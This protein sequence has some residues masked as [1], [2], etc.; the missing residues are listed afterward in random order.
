MARAKREGDLGQAEEG[1]RTKPGYS[2]PP[3]IGEKRTQPPVAEQRDGSWGCGELTGWLVLLV[4]GA[5][6]LI[7]W[8]IYKFTQSCDIWGEFLGMCGFLWL[9]FPVSACLITGI[10]ACACHCCCKP[11]VQGDTIV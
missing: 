6:A 10:C 2:V 9:V 4:V 8:I 1:R 11:V 7:L 5:I 3:D